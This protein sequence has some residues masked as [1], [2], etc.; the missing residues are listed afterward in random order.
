MSRKVRIGK[1]YMKDKM[2]FLLQTHII[3]YSAL[4]LLTKRYD[5][6]ST[7]KYE[8]IQYFSRLLTLVTMRCL[9]YMDKVTDNKFE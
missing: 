3:T 7:Y 9:H 1:L 2:V 4:N 5:T 8:T 6:Y